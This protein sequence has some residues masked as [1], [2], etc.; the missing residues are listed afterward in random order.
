[1]KKLMGFFGRTLV[2]LLGIFLLFAVAFGAG[3]LLQPRGPKPVIPEGMLQVTLQDGQLLIGWPDRLEIAR[4]RIEYS[5]DGKEYTQLGVF[6]N[7]SVILQET[8]ENTPVYLKLRPIRET[9]NWLGV[10]CEKQGD[11]SDIRI[12]PAV[13][14]A[15]DLQSDVDSE[16]KRIFFSCNAKEG[17]GFEISIQNDQ[18]QWQ[19]VAETDSA[20]I[21]L[22]AGQDFDVLRGRDTILFTGR[23]FVRKGGYTAYSP[24]AKPV[25]IAHSD[26]FGDQWGITYESLSDR[27]YALQWE[28]V[29]GKYGEVQQWSA[30]EEDW[31]TKAV[32][33]QSVTRYETGTLP[34][35][36][37]VKF[38]VVSYDNSD[39]RREEVYAQAPYE[40][41][42]RTE[43]SPLYC[44]VWPLN[45]QTLWKNADGTAALAKIPAGETLC[46]LGEE[47]NCFEV[48]YRDQIG[49]VDQR[50]CMIDLREYLGDLCEYEIRNGDASLFRVHGYE[51]PQISGTR[52]RGYEHTTLCD[53]EYLVPLLYPTARILLQAANA[54]RRDGYRLR[55]YD[56]FR[57][58]EAT[59]YLYD[60]MSALMGKKAEGS[61]QT[62]AAIMTGNR[63]GLSSFLAQTVSA[64]NRGIALDLTLVEEETGTE[65]SMQTSMHDLSWYSSTADNN[66]NA[67]LLARYMSLA[68]FNGLVSEWWHFQDDE[69]REELQLNVYLKEGVTPKGWKKD[70]VGWKYRREDGSFCRSMMLEI[71][72]K[73]RT[74]DE[75]GYCLNDF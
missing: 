64:H 39:Q 48:R 63:Y 37:Q 75:N 52:I 9:V 23:S 16:D 42:F 55:I 45:E 65:L 54:V 68:G 32:L 15:P 36:T 12:E 6:S 51:I 14:D 19:S 29:P 44:T 71:D 5:A 11:L 47:E 70:D 4:C 72:G 56:A 49:Y 22:G 30:K 20:L 53:G 27:R 61:E 62:Y 35:G 33:S 18:G 1:M 13:L 34:S 28:P 38:R 73:Q 57:P 31:V 43:V 59:R 25:E 41:T 2:T 74:F 40:L 69:I 3:L 26:L 10:S 66:E 50:Y 67:N 46:V 17:S 58:N 7:H 21:C 60:T 8:Q 24:Y